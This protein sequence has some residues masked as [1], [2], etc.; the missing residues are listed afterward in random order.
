MKTRHDHRYTKDHEW[1]HVKGQ[2]ATIGITDY[3]QDALGSV[4]Y[5]ELPQVGDD[6]QRGDVLGAVESVKAASEIYA[7]LAGRVLRVNTALED[8]PEQL[9]EAPYDQ[10]LAV[11]EVADP[12]EVDDL[13]DEAAYRAFCE[14]EAT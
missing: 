13:M 6:L 4:V 7:P 3:A 10:W 14:Q 5:V 9:N 11:L 2:E 1:V 12:A 8:E